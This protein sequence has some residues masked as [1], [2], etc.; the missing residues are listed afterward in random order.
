MIRLKNED[1][2]NGI[3]KSCHLLADMFKAVIPQVKA[4]MSTKELDDL[5]KKFIIAHGGKPAWYRENFPGA[6]CISINDEV[7]HGIPSKKRIIKDGDIVSID[8][9]IDLDGYIS[10]STHSVLVGNV[11]S[12][13]R[14]L[15]EVT[16][17]C[18][19]AGIEACRVGNRIKD[20]SK[21]VYD[22]ASRH[23]YGVVYDYCGHGVGLDVHED[24]NIPNV[25]DWGGA[26][27]RIQSGMVLASEPMI[28]LGTADV[29]LAGDDWTVLTADGLPSAHEEHTVA[30]FADHTE[31]LTALD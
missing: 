4:G 3:R 9:G 1:E 27:P 24:P 30:V 15:D 12:K 2:I 14:K 8:V 21:A 31:I 25:V 17:E 10:D 16:L 6:A 13:I 5:C 7:I 20:I 19:K 11:D 26:N 23:G 22:I 18:L 28:N 29:V